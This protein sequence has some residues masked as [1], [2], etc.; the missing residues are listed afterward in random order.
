MGPTHRRSERALD[1][2]LLGFGDRH[3]G[4]RGA[5]LGEKRV[6]FVT[7]RGSYL[8]SYMCVLY[9][10]RNEGTYDRRKCMLQH[11]DSEAC[12][13][14]ATRTHFGLY[15]TARGCTT[16][17]RNDVQYTRS[18]RIAGRAE[19]MEYYLEKQSYFWVAMWR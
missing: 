18:L 13:C 16:S 4:T 15:S 9:E 8:N 2:K 5:G 17:N 14:L 1:W 11:N 12:R 7:R 3:E 10:D 19:K 6:T